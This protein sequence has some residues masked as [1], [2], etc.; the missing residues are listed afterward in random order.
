MAFGSVDRALTSKINLPK[1]PPH[2][3]ASRYGLG[4]LRVPTV[5]GKTVEISAF[6]IGRMIADGSA[7]FCRS[8]QNEPQEWHIHVDE[9]IDERAASDLRSMLFP[10][11][12]RHWE[13]S[14]D[15]KGK[16]G[17]SPDVYLKV[18]EMSQPR[19]N[20]DFILFD[21]APD[22]DGPMLSVLRR[23]TH[24]QV[25]HVGDPYQQ[26]YEW[27]GAVNAMEHIK[28]KECA[29]TESFR[30]GPLFATLASKI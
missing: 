9:K 25:I 5:I 12:V 22:S 20:S 1:E 15:Q 19:I 30:F 2:Y 21:E 13:E 7:R 23:Q 26:I 8:A 16:A 18:W 4:P 10:H 3:L 11:V 29:L 27:R 28:A 14:V 24:S 6:Q 17:I